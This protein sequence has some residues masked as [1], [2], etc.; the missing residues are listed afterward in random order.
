MVATEETL[1]SISAS[2][3]NDLMNCERKWA[4]GHGIDPEVQDQPA[5]GSL[6]LGGGVHQAIEA[7]LKGESPNVALWKFVAEA[8]AEGD[9]HELLL[10][11]GQSLVEQFQAWHKQTKFVPTA[12][13]EELR[14]DIAGFPFA[15]FID[16]RDERTIWDW[17]T[18]TAPWD[19][20]KKA[21]AWLQGTAY[22]VGVKQALGIDIE[23]V[24]F[25]VL[26]YGVKKQKVGKFGPYSQNEAGVYG[27]EEVEVPVGDAEVRRLETLVRA[28]APRIQSTDINDYP[29]RPAASGNFLCDARWC[30][31]F[32]ICPGGAA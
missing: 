12:L 6:V 15:G 2:S 18:A 11:H 24:N 29:I 30:S 10:Q 7:H 20:R 19:K 27:Y 3:L 1:K 22:K 5:T 14:F 17:K 32:N 31:F 26:S 13:E 9:E 23:R 21:N 8:K 28:Y 25:L 4:Y 16:A